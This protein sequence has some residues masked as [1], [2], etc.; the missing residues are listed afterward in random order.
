MPSASVSIVV[1]AKAGDRRSERKA[2]R[3]ARMAETGDGVPILSQDA[4]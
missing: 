3:K 4:V 2:W 1:R